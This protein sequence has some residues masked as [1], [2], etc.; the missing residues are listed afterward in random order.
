[1]W[2][3]LL[4]ILKMMI[5]KNLCNKRGRGVSNSQIVKNNSS[6]F[7]VFAMNSS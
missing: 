1:M 5:I 3:K 6:I 2:H 4:L 7:P